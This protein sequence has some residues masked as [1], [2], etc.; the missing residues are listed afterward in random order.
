MFYKC[1]II[2][3]RNI[4]I[5][6]N[7]IKLKILFY[8]YKYYFKK[9]MIKFIKFFLYFIHICDIL[10]TFNKKIFMFIYENIFSRSLLFNYF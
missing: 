1:K 5:D 3:T 8:S 4:F 9:K 10:C 6:C 2:K 7:F